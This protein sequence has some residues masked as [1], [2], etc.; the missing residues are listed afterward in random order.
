MQSLKNEQ[1]W[2]SVVHLP[3]DILHLVNA[4]RVDRWSTSLMR[5]AEKGASVPA[6]SCKPF[7]PSP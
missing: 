6:T 4:V 5:L 1:G 3:Y 2:I 7:T